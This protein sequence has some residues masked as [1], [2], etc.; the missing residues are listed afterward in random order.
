MELRMITFDF[1]GTV[2]VVTGA[3]S[4]IGRA[5][6]GALA[7]AGGTVFLNDLP[8][9]AALDAAVASLA[10]EGLV[11]HSC[12]AD[13]SD[14]AAVAQ[15]VGGVIARCGRLDYLVNNAATPGTR[16]LIPP[17]DFDRMDE[18]FW[19]SLISIN[20]IGPYRWVKSAAPHLRATGGA[21]VNVASTAGLGRGGSSSVYAATKAALIV[22]TTEWAV[23]LGP[24]V[25]VNAIAPDMV[26]GSGWDCVFDPAALDKTIGRLP[27]RRAGTPTDYAQSIL[28]FLAGAPYV[29]GQTLVVDGGG[30]R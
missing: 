19:Q 21:I 8:G 23:A 17:D 9:S 11:V 12:P 13:Q 2:S 29:T 16:A 20:Q 25:R 4:G 14:P 5:T 28:W 15:A 10:A 7:R 26:V 18:A 24:Q 3:A 30:V 27:L 22:L 6:A 1:A